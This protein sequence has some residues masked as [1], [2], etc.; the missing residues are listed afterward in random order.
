L[1]IL[2]CIAYPAVAHL[3]I[4]NNKNTATASSFAAAASGF[5]PTPIVLASAVIFVALTALARV[6][7]LSKYSSAADKGYVII[8]GILGFIATAALFALEPK[9]AFSWNPDDAATALGSLL[10]HISRKTA[11]NLPLSEAITVLTPP[12]AVVRGTLSFLAM[13]ISGL[14]LASSLRFVRAYRLQ[15]EPPAWAVD[16]LQ[17]LNWFASFKLNLLLALPA[18]SSLSWTG[19][20]FK[21]ALGLTEHQA[22]GIRAL[23]AIAT[24]LVFLSTCRLVLQRYMDT[25]LIA[26]HTYKHGARRSSTE[27]AKAADIIQLHAHAVRELV[28]KAAVQVV[29]PGVFYLC[30]GLALATLWVHPA[31]SSGGEVLE[32][33]QRVVSCVAGFCIWWAGINWVVYCGVAL[34]LY[35][36]GTLN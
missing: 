35:R 17:Q 20:L 13:I 33:T 31:G 5:L 6:D 2:T 1:A 27:R 22:A 18:V 3:F 24:G 30:A 23:L 10:E 9:G 28:G 15:Q 36:T 7:F 34:W 21:D 16:Q 19:P 25:A 8:F 29:A 32:Y 12:P 26:W 4:Q 11:P 14:F